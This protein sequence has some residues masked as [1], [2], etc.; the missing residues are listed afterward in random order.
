[1]KRL[2]TLVFIIITFIIPITS[3]AAQDQ[4]SQ[5]L[6]IPTGTSKTIFLTLDAD[7]NQNMFK[8]YQSHKVK[9]WYDPKIINYLDRQ[10]IPTTFF[11]SGLFAE[12]YPEVIGQWASNPLFSIQNHSYDESGFIPHC[13]WLKTLTTDDQKLEQV[14][15]TEKILTDLTSKPPAYFRYPG[16]C[17]NSSDDKLVESLNLKINEGDIIAS[18]PFNHNAAKIVA[19][20]L[21]QLKDNGVIVMHVGG[22]NAPAS[23]E[24]IKTLIPKIQ[25]AGYNFKKLP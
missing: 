18:D 19:N 12:T 9:L 15:K 22:K 3:N 23:Y 17:H 4:V 11:V 10:H 6:P 14:K 25:E 20:V 24:A 1:M 13:Y 5:A 8:R 21:R 7:M 16:L 2:N